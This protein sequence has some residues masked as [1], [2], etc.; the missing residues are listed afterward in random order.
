MT[1][2]TPDPENAEKQEDDA[3]SLAS[4]THGVRLAVPMCSHESRQIN[5]PAADSPFTA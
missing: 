1:G 4:S 5:L 3:S 2:L